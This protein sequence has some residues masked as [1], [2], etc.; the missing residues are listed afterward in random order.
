M[1]PTRKSVP[2]SSRQSDH[3]KPDHQK[4]TNCSGIAMSSIHQVWPKSFAR[5]SEGE[6]NRQ[7]EEDVGKQHQEMDR[8]G[9]HQVPEGS[10]A[11]RRMEETGQGIAEGDAEQWR[12]L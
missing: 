12:I 6:E 11:Q 1:L 10:G 7:T 4:D 8:P 5:H 3:T 9:V 2:R